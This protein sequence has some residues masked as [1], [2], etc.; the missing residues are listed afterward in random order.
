[1]LASFMMKNQG[2][3][4]NKQ[5]MQ[6]QLASAKLAICL[7]NSVETPQKAPTFA[8]DWRETSRAPSHEGALQ[9]FNDLKQLHN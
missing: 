1:M 7:K 2:G 4:L 5:T 3:R 6:V 9:R 8:G